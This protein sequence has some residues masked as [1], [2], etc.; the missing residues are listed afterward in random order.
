M[1]FVAS[2]NGVIIGLVH[3]QMAGLEKHVAVEARIE[4][5]LFLFKTLKQRPKQGIVIGTDWTVA[6]VDTA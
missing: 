4:K 1:D 3:A 2:Q 6:T 5:V